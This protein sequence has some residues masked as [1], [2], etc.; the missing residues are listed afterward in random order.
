MITVTQKSFQGEQSIGL[1]I[2]EGICLKR[3]NAQF[4]QVGIDEKT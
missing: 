4:P 2:V 1:E 3:E